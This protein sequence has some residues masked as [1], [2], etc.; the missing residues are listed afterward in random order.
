MNDFGERGFRVLCFPCNQFGSQEPWDL[1]K[2]RNFVETNFNLPQSKSFQIGE[3]IEVNGP[4][5]APL[6][7]W[8]R[9][10]TG[11]HGDVKW[12]F[13]TAFLVDR[14]GNPTR[15]DTYRWANM[16]KRVQKAVSEVQVATTNN[17]EDKI[18]EP[19]PV[20]MQDNAR[21]PR[22]SAENPVPV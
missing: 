15:Y 5:T 22:L 13:N 2:I 8:L 9:N 16:T 17:L 11:E 6:Y 21:K 4:G 12:N 18:E 7:N 10:E 14:K 19:I 1:P 3:K 20:T